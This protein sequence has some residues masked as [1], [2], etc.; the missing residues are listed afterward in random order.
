[1]D[2]IGP[3]S[4]VT[5]DGSVFVGIVVFVVVAVAISQ[6]VEVVSAYETRVLTVFGE[7]RRLLEPGVNFVPPFVSRTYAFDMRAQTLDVPRETYLTR[8]D[9]LVAV[10]VDL[11]VQISDTETL[12]HATDDYE[13]VVSERCEETLRE[14]LA[15]A[16]LDDALYGQWV[17]TKVQTELGRQVDE[18]G[19]RIDGVEVNEATP[20]GDE[21]R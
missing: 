8:D 9:S 14:V 19:I 20:V 11:D 2:V 10:D 18:F 17:E 5:L 4:G 6:S 7:Y 16:S 12:F 1:M 15:A 21:T 3:N 13:R